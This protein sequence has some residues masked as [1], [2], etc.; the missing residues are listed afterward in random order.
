MAPMVRAGDRGGG[1]ASGR[2]GHGDAFRGRHSQPPRLRDLA[3]GHGCG[4]RRG[5]CAIVRAPR[6]PTRMA[7]SVTYRRGGRRRRLG[8]S[9]GLAAAVHRGR[10][11]DRGDGLRLEGHRHGIT[12][13]DRHATHP[14]GEHCGARISARC[15]SG[16]ARLRRRVASARRGW[17][18]R[19]DHQTAAR[20]RVPGHGRPRAG[21][22]VGDR[23]DKWV[24]G[25]HSLGGTVAAL[26]ADNA[27]PGDVDGLLLFASYPLG[28]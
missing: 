4:W 9:H 14:R 26:T 27:E 25:G 22:G 1:P 6:E 21:T 12:H 11:R 17:P 16:P 20:H 13:P 10:A 19:G 23:R 24:V 8:A 28:T 18:P 15:S 2:V 3:W 5:S 7:A